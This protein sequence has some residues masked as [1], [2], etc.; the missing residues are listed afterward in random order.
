[1]IQPLRWLDRRWTFDLP[2]GAFPAILERLRGTPARAAELLASASNA[3]VSAQPGGAW[4]AKE[5]IAHIDDL[6]D[7]DDRRLDEF[8]AGAAALSAADMTNRKTHAA[9]HNDRSIDDIVSTLRRHREALIVRMDALTDADVE[10]VSLHPRLQ[11]PIRLIDW[12]YFVA[13]H[14]DHHLVQAR[15]AVARAKGR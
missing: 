14:D 10:R 8:A 3:A 1:M 15:R 9:G 7:L 2:P 12:S 13:E 11:R 5:H 6:H 4:S